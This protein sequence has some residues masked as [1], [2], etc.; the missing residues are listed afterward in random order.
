MGYEFEYAI[1]AGWGVDPETLVNIE[2]LL[3]QP[4]LS[5]PPDEFPVRTV[6]LD[7][8]EWG[9]GRVDHELLFLDFIPV[10]KIKVIEDTFHSSGTV[11]SAPVTLQVRHHQRDAYALYEAY[12]ILPQPQEDFT[13]L[14]YMIDGELV[15]SL[16]WRFHR[17]R[18]V[19]D[20]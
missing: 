5:Q 12:S 10:S 9:D 15:C 19:E 18:V 20:A 1:A 6:T 14:D 8:Q 16:R 4:P 17:L 13:V 2:A 11:V 7:G 3:G